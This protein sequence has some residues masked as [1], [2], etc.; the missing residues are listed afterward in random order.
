MKPTPKFWSWSDA[1]VDRAMLLDSLNTVF[2]WT[3][4]T[5][6]QVNPRSLRNFPMQANGAGRCCD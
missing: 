5:S 3:I 6:T 1:A 4:H 2:G